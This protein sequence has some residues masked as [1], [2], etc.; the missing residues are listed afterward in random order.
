MEF[1]KQ[2]LS[3]CCGLS[4]PVLQRF[5]RDR[6]LVLAVEASE[7]AEFEDVK[8]MHNEDGVLWGFLFSLNFRCWHQFVT[9]VA[10]AYHSHTETRNVTSLHHHS[11]KPSSTLSE[12]VCSFVTQNPS[13]LC[14]PIAV[15]SE[16]AWAMSV[17]IISVSCIVQGLL[18]S[19]SPA[20]LLA[21]GCG[22]QRR[23]CFRA[24]FAN[25]VSVNKLL[26]LFNKLPTRDLNGYG[27]LAAHW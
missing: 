19:W 2:Q 11:C 16:E 20:L 12:L 21:E 8:R 7:V 24:S 25:S 5:L 17:E 10:P 26:L 9:N 15:R 23:W 14:L 6:L 3:L 13:G 18:R 4:I 27:I 22:R 1:Y